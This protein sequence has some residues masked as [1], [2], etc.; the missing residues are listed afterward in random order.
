MEKICTRCN[1]RTPAG[2]SICQV[3]GCAK[4]HVA[5]DV[6]VAVAKQSA[7]L[8]SE[9]L[10]VQAAL[11]ALSTFIK[12]IT[13]TSEAAFTPAEPAP[14]AIEIPD[15]QVFKDNEDLDS[16]IAWFKSY[17]VDRPLILQQKEQDECDNYRAA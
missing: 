15:K 3:C 4:F 11:N 14:R 5:T 1:F 7:P 6:Q 12:R 17:G 8:V 2:R 10:N 9:Q 16:M 13:P